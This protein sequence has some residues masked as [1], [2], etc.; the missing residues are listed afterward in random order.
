[1]V[2]KMRIAITGAAGLLGEKLVKCCLKEDIEV[3]PIDLSSAPLPSLDGKVKFLRLDITNA[4]STTSMIKELK[5]DAVINAAAMT[6]VDQCEVEKEAA[7]KVNVEGPKSIAQACLK[8]GALAVHI[9]TS[10]VFD[11]AK[12]L[13]KEEDK[14]NP[15]NYYGL[16]K[17]KGEEYIRNIAPSWCIARTDVIFGWGRMDRPNFAVWVINNL[18]KKEKMKLIDDQYNSPTLNTNLAEMLVEAA[19]RNLT[20]I[21]NL[22]GATRINRFDFARAICKSFQL[23]EKLISPIKSNQLNWKAKRPEDASLNVEK[24]KKTLTH[25]PLAMDVALKVLREERE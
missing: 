15:I 7:W 19:K 2:N 21:F 11:G 14:T 1:M 10:Y 13:Y 24:A 20:G 5:P 12:G 16:T 3:Y 4:E 23:D 8:V 17:L 6:N 9:S 22:S 18:E 25:K